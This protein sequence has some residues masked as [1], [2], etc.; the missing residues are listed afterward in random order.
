M[1]GKNPSSQNTQT[2]RR[3]SCEI[4]IPIKL[5]TQCKASILFGSENGEVLGLETWPIFTFPM[6]DRAET[7]YTVTSDAE[8]AM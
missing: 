8:K 3:A 2:V 4:P 7:S 1:Y 5:C 6:S